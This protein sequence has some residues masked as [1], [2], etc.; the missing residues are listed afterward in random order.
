MIDVYS[1]LKGHNA[2]IFSNRYA[3]V[4]TTFGQEPS[5]LLVVMIRYL[6]GGKCDLVKTVT[7]LDDVEGRTGTRH[8]E[9]LAEGSYKEVEK[10]LKRLKRKLCAQEVNDSHEALERLALR[11]LGGERDRRAD[12]AR[13]AAITATNREQARK[14]LAQEAADK[15]DI[16][17]ADTTEREPKTHR[18]SFLKDVGVPLAAG[19]LVGAA[20]VLLTFLI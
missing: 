20:F 13:R 14:E 1:L 4:A 7:E 6:E 17:R 11:M 2:Y 15:E 8:E 19:S 9:I 5:Y 18:R 12:D 3:L 10:E 16:D